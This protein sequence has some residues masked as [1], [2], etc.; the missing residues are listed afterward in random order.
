MD[1]EQ[2]SCRRLTVGMVFPPYVLEHAQVNKIYAEISERYPYQQLQHLPD[3]A[4]MSNQGGDC[5]IQ[6]T[7]LQVNESIDYFHSTKDKAL[8]LFNIAQNR[9]NIPLFSN[10]GIK[11]TAGVPVE[12]RDAAA[13]LEST[14][15][16]S[17]KKNLEKLG[18]DRKGTGMRIVVHREGIHEIKIEPLFSDISQIYIELDVQYPQP[19][20]DINSTGPKMTAAYDYLFGDIRDFLESL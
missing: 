7:R 8:D 20:S 17:I 16:A 3:G 12:S 10:F 11:I 5:F 14:A 15:F 18:G 4:R 19:F 13:A 9:L 1:T 6:T 2:L